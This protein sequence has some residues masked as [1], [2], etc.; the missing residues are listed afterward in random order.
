MDKNLVRQTGQQSELMQPQLEPFRLL[1]ELMNWEP[2]AGMLP[3][4]A[5]ESMGFTPRFEVKE[6]KD[7]Y[8][9]KA[10]LPGIKEENLDITLTGNR[11]AVSG[12]REAEQRVEGDTYYTY[13]RSY[14][15]FSRSFTL[16]EGVDA[17]NISADLKN[18]VLSVSIPKRPEHQPKKISLK[19]IGEKVKAM[20]GGDKKDK[21]QA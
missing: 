4:V 15:S 20:L 21:D 7:A 3:S 9:F 14:G 1:R 17:E 8:V 16:P 18:G 13:E 6:T 5:G 10:D 11:L 12:H 2:L 19:S